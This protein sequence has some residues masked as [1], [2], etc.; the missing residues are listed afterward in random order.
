M[1]SHTRRVAAAAT[2]AIVLAGALVTIEAVTRVPSAD[3]QFWD[4]QDTSAWAQDSGGIATGGDANPFNGFGY[5]KLQVARP[6]GPPL[7]S[8]QYLKGFGLAYDG[9]DRFDSITPILSEGIVVARA[10]RARKDQD[11]LRYV[12]TFTNSTS[13]PRVVRVAWG[14]AAGA[15]EDGGRV[16]VAETSSGDRLIDASDRFVTVMQNARGVANPAQ[17]PS[18]HGPSSHVLGNKAGVRTGV[19]DM[20][21]D[22][23][24]DRWPG[25][26]PAHIGYVYYAAA[27]TRPDRRARHVR[28]EGT[29]RG[30]RS[31][32]RIPG[33]GEG[34]PCERRHRLRRRRQEDPGA[35]L[36]DREGHRHCQAPRGRP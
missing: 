9:V 18:G 10:I 8:N 3:G 31:A 34:R 27:R 33:D 4:V 25:F 20:Y 29:E 14:G 11:Y 1:T 19:G 32:W 36:G 12:D 17:G 2:A 30:L 16:A 15:F 21:S 35:G 24:T 13:E 5:L 6:A 22:P 26:D 23:F 7:V 28:G